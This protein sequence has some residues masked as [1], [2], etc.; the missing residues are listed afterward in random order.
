MR[1]RRP[2]GALSAVVG[3]SLSSL[4]AVQ[5]SA[6]C[7]MRNKHGERSRS[8]LPG[9]TDALRAAYQPAVGRRGRL[10]PATT[11][12]VRCPRYRSPVDTRV[13]NAGTDQRM[14]YRRTGLRG[15]RGSTGIQ[16]LREIGISL[17]AT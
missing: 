2:L 3:C 4:I 11:I 7:E 15:D 1:S 5:Y 17:A 12:L 13:Y 9:G 16:R 14:E 10:L 8:Q 6:V